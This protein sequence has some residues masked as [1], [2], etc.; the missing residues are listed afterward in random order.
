MDPGRNARLN[1]VC[2][3]DASRRYGGLN[4]DE[5]K[6]ELR[7]YGLPAN[8]N[9]ADLVNR[10]C[11]HIR[12]IGGILNPAPGQG[13]VQVQAQGQAQ[14]QAQAQVQVQVQAP[15]TVPAAI[16]DALCNRN[17]AR[18]SGGMNIDDMKTVLSQMG[19][20]SAGN[21]SELKTRLC[22]LRAAAPAVANPPIANPAVAN[23]PIANPAT[24][25]VANPATPPTGPANPP[26]ARPTI[27]MRARVRPQVQAQAQ[28]QVLSPVRPQGVEA[29]NVQQ[30]EEPST[31]LYVNPTYEGM[32]ADAEEL[33]RLRWIMRQKARKDGVYFSVE[34]AR[35]TPETR[36]VQY[37]PGLTP[38][39]LRK[40]A[41]HVYNIYISSYLPRVNSQEYFLDDLS[42]IEYFQTYEEYN[43]LF[44]QV[45]EMMNY[46]DTYPVFNEAGQPTGRT[47]DT[48]KWI[49]T[50][51]HPLRRLS[52][53]PDF[54][55]FSEIR[56][57][58]KYSESLDP[59]AI[60]YLM[61]ITYDTYLDH[62]KYSRISKIS[63]ADLGKIP[64][65]DTFKAYANNIL[66]TA[67][68]S[69]LSPSINI[70]V[71][72]R[73]KVK[74]PAYVT[75]W[76][77]TLAKGDP[78]KLM[79]EYVRLLPR[80]RYCLY[81]YKVFGLIKFRNLNLTTKT[82]FTMLAEINKF[83]DKHA[84]VL[85]F[86][87]YYIQKMPS[88]FNNDLQKDH[89]MNSKRE[90]YLWDTHSYFTVTEENLY[91]S[92]IFRVAPA[93]VF[94]GSIIAPLN[95]P[96][97]IL[98]NQGVQTL[99]QSVEDFKAKSRKL[100]QLVDQ[101]CPIERV[102]CIPRN[103]EFEPYEKL[104]N[105]ADK[106]CARLQKKNVPLY[107]YYST[108]VFDDTRP[109]ILVNI[110]MR[111]SN[112]VY[113]FN[114]INSLYQKSASFHIAF[115]SVDGTN[116]GVDLGGI[117]KSV[118]T[119]AGSYIR[120]IM[121]KPEGS[122]CYYFP[123][124]MPAGSQETILKCILMS[125]HHGYSLGVT[126][127]NGIYY[128]FTLAAANPLTLNLTE[129]IL[130]M[131]IGL[132]LALYYMD[133]PEDTI[134]L[135]NKAT[136]DFQYIQYHQ[137]NEKLLPKTRQTDETITVDREDVMEWLRRA[138]IYKMY[139]LKVTDSK[140]ESSSIG[141]FGLAFSNIPVQYTPWLSKMRS[142]G[143]IKTLSHI[144]GLNITRETVL[145][146]TKFTGSTVMRNHMVRFINEASDDT[147]K[148]M[149]YFI[150]GSLDPAANI[151]IQEV[152]YFTGLPVAQTC[153]NKLVVKPY[154]AADYETVTAGGA[155][156]VG[157]K[158]DLLLSIEHSG[159]TFGLA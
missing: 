4:I 54:I 15:L 29:Y 104:L 56:Q 58:L 101:P 39:E 71:N 5:L 81:M 1:A 152:A 63:Q 48:M 35:F 97:E 95:Q 106:Y 41:E 27:Q 120:S 28:A 133:N 127:S 108:R 138:L 51:A 76:I 129:G 89:I 145:R 6:N 52:M 93:K 20:S 55:T 70:P 116:I 80:Y 84:P 19:L 118:F 44:D 156:P 8:G 153:F 65:P 86:G 21:R 60:V 88:S 32:S 137:D 96:R 10:L 9:R 12:V 110:N 119:R 14:A 49:Q 90:T 134:T 61:Q 37:L 150:T 18:S 121:H 123:H 139:G 117:T 107:R 53:V 147:L 83:I 13:P 154:T 33:N 112:D 103:P 87:T 144:V 2:D 38:A 75:K 124:K 113:F 62:L 126:F 105:M 67:G 57:L 31:F 85:L 40:Y 100:N 142:L 45:S 36:Y 122:T 3:T 158:P 11:N 136:R 59:D 155:R 77:D 64:K 22:N 146:M 109:R 73:V 72:L 111:D 74:H 135:L 114:M 99:E 46:S 140:P 82:D 69:G 79:I 91:L 151:T 7:G 78:S 132:L 42:N 47:E 130:S 98:N 141:K 94:T 128:L 25:P 131:N 30:D 92:T 23:P 148:K 26:R 34:S 16:L 115:S 102:Q 43:L 143:T 68:E 17:A 157:F 24:P 125:I 66:L 50:R 159:D 149:L